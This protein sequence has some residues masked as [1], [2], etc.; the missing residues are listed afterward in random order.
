MTKSKLM[1]IV[2]LTVFL[3]LILGT[4][5]LAGDPSGATT[6]GI[7]D[8]TAAKAGQPTSESLRMGPTETGLTEWLAE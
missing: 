3:V 7:A 4:V 1:K 2:F 5:A 8:I 6:G